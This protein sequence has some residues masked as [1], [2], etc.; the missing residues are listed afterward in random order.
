MGFALH[1]IDDRLI[2][3]QVLVAWGSRLDPRRI[4]VVDDA[5]SASAW[6][7]A[8]F[9]DAAPGIGVQVFTVDEAAAA[10]AAEATSAGSTFFLV[11][12]LATARRL[13]NAG[14]RVRVW[15][16]GGLHYSPG[17]TKVNDYVYLDDADRADARILLAAGVTLEVQ[18]VPASKG[19]T[20][21]ALEPSV[22]P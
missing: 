10:Y 18:D 3:G 19:M 12:D 14:V 15:N 5:V 9:A 2:H 13:H 1:R 16:L 4:W 6:E 11:R 21:V 22:Q 7:K 17:K 20:L 8:L